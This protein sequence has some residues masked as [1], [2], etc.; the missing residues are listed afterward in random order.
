MKAAQPV[1]DERLSAEEDMECS[2]EDDAEIAGASMGALTLTAAEER[3]GT[4]AGLDTA[5][6][7]ASLNPSADV[8][9]A[10]S[11]RPCAAQT[12]KEDSTRAA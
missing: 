7:L 5:R 3:G 11:R 4:S 6:G 2:P 12:Y 9:A 10:E 8:P 1:E